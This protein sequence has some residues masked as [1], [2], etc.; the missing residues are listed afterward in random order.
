MQTSVLWQI[1]DKYY[2]REY[3]GKR[4]SKSQDIHA[5]WLYVYFIV[6]LSMLIIFIRSVYLLVYLCLFLWLEHCLH[7]VDIYI[8]YNPGNIIWIIFKYIIYWTFFNSYKS[9]FKT[10]FKT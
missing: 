6:C 5:L 8:D 3:V 2:C 10:K 4:N 7:V 1:A 9:I